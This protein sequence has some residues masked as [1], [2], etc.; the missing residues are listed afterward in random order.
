MCVSREAANILSFSLTS[1]DEDEYL[2]EF[3]TARENIYMSLPLS[4]IWIL[5]EEICSL[6]YMEA[7]IVGATGT[8]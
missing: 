5:L 1:L 7:H 3:P 4:C 2:K 6:H 8:D